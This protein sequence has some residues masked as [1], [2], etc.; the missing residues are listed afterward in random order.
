MGGR[1]FGWWCGGSGRFA[2]A[3]AQKRR[4]NIKLSF[5]LFPNIPGQG[6]NIMRFNGN[7]NNL[8]TLDEYDYREPHILEYR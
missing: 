7:F 4:K 8:F 2:A 3:L 1:Q 5:S 6:Q